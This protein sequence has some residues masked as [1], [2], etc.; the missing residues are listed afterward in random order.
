MAKIELDLL[1]EVEVSDKLLK[2][3]NSNEPCDGTGTKH[4]P[5]RCVGFT[6]LECFIGRNIFLKNR[7]SVFCKEFKIL[8]GGK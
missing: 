3:L 1:I 8:E 4:S 5:F 7:A 6:A 2:E